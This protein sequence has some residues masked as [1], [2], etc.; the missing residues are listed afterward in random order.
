M[1][2]YH[3]RSRRS[4]ALVVLVGKA[5]PTMSGLIPEEHA[6]PRVTS[7]P[8]GLHTSSASYKRKTEF[9]T[10]SRHLRPR[11][12]LTWQPRPGGIC[13]KQPDIDPCRTLRGDCPISRDSYRAFSHG[14]EAIDA[15]QL[16]P[17]IVDSWTACVVDAPL[18]PIDPEAAGEA[19]PQLESAI[20][21]SRIKELEIVTAS[22]IDGDDDDD[23]IN[24]NVVIDPTLPTAPH[25]LIEE[26][27]GR[28]STCS[29]DQ[30]LQFLLH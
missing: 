29:H 30:L 9:A 8:G 11:D 28:S 21:D 6:L 17:A 18:S 5:K 14:S 10:A 26:T 24:T 19:E 20:V 15:E 27:W 25:P 13:T 22:T 7:R 16:E 23:D 2:P 3:V 4:K 1:P 12:A